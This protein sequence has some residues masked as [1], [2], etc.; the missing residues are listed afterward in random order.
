MEKV[1]RAMC[2]HGAG[3]Y[4]HH[5]DR[6]DREA[7]GDATRQCRHACALRPDSFDPR[8]VTCVFKPDDL[9]CDTDVPK[10]LGGVIQLERLQCMFGL[11]RKTFQK[12]RPD[13]PNI[14]GTT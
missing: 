14:C 13:R 8:V 7:S 10:E 6:I 12:I 11:R 2:Q 9:D 5:G 3:P 4:V 1:S